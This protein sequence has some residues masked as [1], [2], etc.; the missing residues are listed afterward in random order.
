VHSKIFKT[1]ELRKIIIFDKQSRK[2]K[3]TD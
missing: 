1:T 2:N 3:T